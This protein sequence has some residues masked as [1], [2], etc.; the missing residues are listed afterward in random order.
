MTRLIVVGAGPAGLAAAMFS[1]RRGHSVILVEHDAD[2]PGMDAEASFEKWNRRAV[3]Q[4]RQL[5]N[6]LALSFRV[7]LE[8]AP[9]VYAT[10]SEGAAKE[11]MI[12]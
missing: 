11:R 1:A 2:R 6:F 10:L 8:E 7:L 9:E 3:G 5:H 12:N 4:F